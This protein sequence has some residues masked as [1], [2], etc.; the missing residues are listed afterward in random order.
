[1]GGMERGGR[2]DRKKGGQVMTGQKKRA[3]KKIGYSSIC[4]GGERWGRGG[5]NKGRRT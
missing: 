2:E 3:K 1:L 5:G 4:V